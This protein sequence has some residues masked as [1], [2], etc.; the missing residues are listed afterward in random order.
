[1]A[2]C[3]HKVFEKEREREREREFLSFDSRM[4]ENAAREVRLWMDAKRE[5]EREREREMERER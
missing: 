4:K 3:V 2:I 5:R 1:M